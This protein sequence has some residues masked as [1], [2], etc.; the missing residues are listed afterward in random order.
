[1][2]NLSLLSRGREVS[3]PGELYLSKAADYFLKAVHRDFDYVVLDSS[4]VMAADDT[5]SLAPKA[6]AVDFRFSLHCFE[7]ARQP[8]SAGNAA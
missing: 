3:S 5:T 2:P 8:E 7:R 6:D 4:P 1:M